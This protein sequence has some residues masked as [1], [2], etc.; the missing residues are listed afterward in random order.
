MASK[1]NATENSENMNVYIPTSIKT[2]LD[3]GDH[4]T[5]QSRSNGEPGFDDIGLTNF[6]KCVICDQQFAKLFILNDT[7]K[8]IPKEHR[9]VVTFAGKGYIEKS[10]WKRHQFRHTGQQPYKCVRCEKSF[11]DEYCLKLHIRTHSGEQL[12]RCEFCNKGY[13]VKSL[14]IRHRRSHTAERPFKCEIYGESFADQHYLGIHTKVHTGDQK[15]KCEICGKGY[16][17]N[18]KIL[19]HMMSH[20]GEHPHISVVETSTD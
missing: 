8:H 7:C 6:T 15:Y 1:S 20:T 17:S 16:S 10:A 13:S 19:A 9:I 11:A 14:L 18:S 3:F 2:K 4:T 12:F 5:K